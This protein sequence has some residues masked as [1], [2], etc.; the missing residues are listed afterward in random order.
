MYKAIKDNK[1]IAIS[2]TDSEFV[3]LAK[4]EVVEDTEHTVDDYDLYYYDGK[5]A[6]YLLKS[7]IPGPTYEEI[8][9]LR[10]QY[11]REH[12]DDK[13]IARMRKTA[14][15]TWTEEDEQ[16]YL[17]LDAKVTAYIEEHYPYPDEN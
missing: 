4:D 17:A 3:C 7:E 8:D 10:I 13:T 14:N 5:N 9:A 1:I 11:R 16:E 2:D 15:G 12:I 6:E